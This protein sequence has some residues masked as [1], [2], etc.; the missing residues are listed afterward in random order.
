MSTKYTL[1]RVRMDIYL[2][3]GLFCQKIDNEWIPCDLADFY[4]FATSIFIALTIIRYINS[5]KSVV[6]KRPKYKLI[7]ISGKFGVGKD[8]A[9]EWIR[10]IHPEYKIVP[11]AD[12]LKRVVAVMTCTSYE[13]QFTREGKAYVPD[14]YQHSVGKY[15]Q[16]L[17]TLGREHFRTDIWVN[18]ALSDP[19]EY[20][21]I[22]DVRFPN[23]ADAI[24]KAGGVLIRINR[25]GVV[26]NDGRDVTHISETA[27]D[28][29]MFYNII[30]NDGNLEE[31]KQKIFWMIK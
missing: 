19:A 13:S 10:D 4:I 20:K 24:K 26:L 6:T 1:V 15:Q 25:N 29:Y 28:N 17:G 16:I 30:M 5:T 3:T 12:A 18:I 9:A 8:T 27:L 11:F 7:G 2:P 22:P 31:F 14:G 23:E 21:I